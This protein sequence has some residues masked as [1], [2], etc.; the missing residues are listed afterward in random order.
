MTPATLLAHGMVRKGRKVKVL[1]RGD[2]ASALTIKAHAFS[3]TA[4]TKI[5]QAGGTAELVG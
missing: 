2:L 3:Q 4:K 1:G 5:E